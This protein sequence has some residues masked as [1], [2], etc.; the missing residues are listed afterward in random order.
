[1]S[2]TVCLRPVYTMYYL[3]GGG[4]LWCF[5]NWAKGLASL[6][7]RVIWLEV[8][9]SDRSAYDAPAHVTALKDYLR[10][11]GLADEVALC[12]ADGSPLPPGTADG[13]LDL[14]EAAAADLLLNM[15][16]NVSAAVVGRFRRSA[17]V[18]IDPGLLQVW[19]SAGQIKTAPHDLYFTIGEMVGRPGALFPDCGLEWHYTPPPVSLPDWPPTAAGPGA[20]YTTVSQWWGEWLEVR[21]EPFDNSKRAGFLD[22]FDLPSRSPAPLELAL[23]LGK[24][25]AEERR[26]MERKGWRV[27][28]AADEVPTPE[29]YRAY[30]RGSR[31]EFSCAKPSCWRLQNAWVSDRSLC[32]LA[33]GKPA[34]VRHTG[35]SRFLPDAEGLFRFRTPDEAARALAAAEV[36]YERHCRLA[37]ALAEEFFDARKVLSRV[38]ERALA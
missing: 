15:G 4:H 7:C 29:Q 35:P 30:V 2:I 28:S 3:T 32:Y 20:P 37:R 8:V 9:P 17:L 19:M 11:H 23:C 26:L 1:M 34:V 10:P 31:G 24:E 14:E 36:D 22:Y 33:S 38:L 21:G 27:R 18:D 13:C 16:Y 6:G 5:L 12:S 25:D